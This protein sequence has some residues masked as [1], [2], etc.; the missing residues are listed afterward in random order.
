MAGP[1]WNPAKDT[2]AG[3]GPLL[4]VVD[5]GWAAARDWRE[6]M[7]RRRGSACAAAARAGRPVAVVATGE[8]AGRHRSWP[9]PAAAL[10][11]LRA[12]QPVAALAGPAWRM[13]AA[14]AAFPG[15]RARPPRSSGS[16]TA[17]PST[18]RGGFVAGAET[19]IGRRSRMTILA[20]PA[21]RP[22]ALAGVENIAARAE[23]ARAARRAERRAT[24]A[25]SARLDR[26]GLP[27]GETPLRLPLR[28][29]GDE[30]R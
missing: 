16:A 28:R 3:T 6:R 19:A 2:A 25:P 30:P 9:M 29:D 21:A 7:H 10:E 13:L 4:L 24:P 5:N 15:A 1:V 8:S 11:R 26:R 20:G 23:R 17:S 12:L 14:A 22:L 27:L 18:E